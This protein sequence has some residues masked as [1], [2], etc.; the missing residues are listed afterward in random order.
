MHIGPPKRLSTLQVG[1]GDRD[2][3]W[4]FRP[5]ALDRARATVSDPTIF[6]ASSPPDL[7][8]FRSECV[9]AFGKERAR[10]ILAAIGPSDMPEFQAGTASATE[11]CNCLLADDWCRSGCCIGLPNGGCYK[12]AD[13]G[14]LLMF[15]ATG[16]VASRVIDIAQL[17]KSYGSTRAVDDVSFRVNPGE[18]TGFLGPNGAGKTTTIRCAV[19]LVK[20]T[21]GRVRILGRQ[22]ANSP[23]PLRDVGAVLSPHAFHPARSGFN[24]LRAVARTNRIGKRRVTE[25]L[26]QTGLAAAAFRPVG[27]YSLGMKQRLAIAQALLGDPPV[28]IFDEPLNGLDVEGIRW[29]RD[30]LA[31][32]AGEGRAVLYSSHLMNEVTQVAEHIVMITRGKL[33]YDGSL[34]RL[35]RTGRQVVVIAGSDSV[36][37]AALLGEVGGEVRRKGELVEVSGLD[38]RE[39]A[40]VAYNGGIR[41]YEQ[42]TASADLETIYLEMTNAHGLSG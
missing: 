7:V 25:L 18:V 17:S 29:V 28:L 11:F 37:L 42:H 40:D 9:D 14:T 34:G 33:V 20:P 27:T 32:C 4:A 3:A 26:D 39:I 22:F 12:W 5:T 38:P 35:L 21:S 24:H 13:C 23:W 36:R 1:I 30:L 16:G 41:I 6:S 2:Q 8:A 15:N 10:Q 19:N 31:S